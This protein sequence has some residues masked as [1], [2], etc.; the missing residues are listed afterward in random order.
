[1]RKFEYASDVKDFLNMDNMAKEIQK[2][3]ES[4]GR[5][6]WR[7]IQTDAVIDSNNTKTY[8]LYWE[9]EIIER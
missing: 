4:R 8:W 7:L 1:M 6:G 5:D 9:R 2:T 3:V